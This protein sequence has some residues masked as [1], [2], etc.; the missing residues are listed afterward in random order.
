LD[1]KKKLKKKK[2][3]NEKQ[4][5]LITD[6]KNEN[7]NT[8]VVSFDDKEELREYLVEELESA[9]GYNFDNGDDIVIYG[10]LLKVNVTEKS[11]KI[12]IK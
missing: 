12:D 2:V 10:E 9:V 6:I 3:T 4:Y 5:H 1:K 7:R 11:Y 8:A